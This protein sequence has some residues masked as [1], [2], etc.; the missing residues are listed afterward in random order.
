M[1][2]SIKTTRDGCSLASLLKLTGFARSG[3]IQ[4]SQY[5]DR[6]SSAPGGRRALS[7]CWF[8]ETKYNPT[9]YLDWL[10]LFLFWFEWGLTLQPRQASSW[11][12]PFLHLKFSNICWAIISL[13][14]PP[15]RLPMPGVLATVWWVDSYS[16]S[17][18]PW[19]SGNRL[20]IVT[21]IKNGNIALLPSVLFVTTMTF[22]TLF[23]CT[24]YL[25]THKS[26]PVLLS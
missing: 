24:L 6:I 3:Y 19:P 1:Y 11:R 21:F 4:V 23:K 18:V 12:Y 14:L 2:K 25:S 9:S 20:V 10:S 26:T 7:H 16:R 5:Y 15:T 17:R 22:Q 8:E 13:L